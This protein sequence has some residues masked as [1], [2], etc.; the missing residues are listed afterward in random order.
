MD[1]LPATKRRLGK[2]TQVFIKHDSLWKSW[3]NFF[4]FHSMHVH[5]CHPG[6][7]DKF[8]TPKGLFLLAKESES[9]S[10]AK[11]LIYELVT[12][13]NQSRSVG[14]C[15]V[16]GLSFRFCFRH[17]QSGTE[18]KRRSRKRSRKRWKRSAWF[19]WLLFHR[20]YDSAYD[21]DFWFSP[22]HKRFYDSAY[23]SDSD[24]VASENQP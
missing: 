17:R 24:S 7:L 21:S 20:T 12:F 19:F 6:Q 10:E 18:R 14:T 23:D 13:K 16:I 9:Y 11:S 3:P 2:S 1:D 22:G 15:I 4:K 5:P 8:S